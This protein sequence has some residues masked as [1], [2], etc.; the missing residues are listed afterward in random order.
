[1]GGSN[2]SIGILW[3]CLTIDGSFRKLQ[4]LLLFV[5]RKLQDLFQLTGPS[6]EVKGHH[7]PEEELDRAVDAL[8]A[9]CEWGG[10]LRD[11]RAGSC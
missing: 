5:F 10:V 2:C 9:T 1:M 3:F 4:D 7:A 11:G 8:L 6:L